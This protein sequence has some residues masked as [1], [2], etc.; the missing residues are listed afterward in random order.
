MVVTGGG[1]T[2]EEVSFFLE[3]ENK[4]TAKTSDKRTFC[5]WKNIFKKR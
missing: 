1:V 4:P 3:H 5:I 2:T